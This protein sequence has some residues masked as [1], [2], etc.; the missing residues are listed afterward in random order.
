MGNSEEIQ[1]NL[2]VFNQ[3][4]LILYL[5]NEFLLHI[6]G[7]LRILQTQIEFKQV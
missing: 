3:R 1:E 5:M 2:F 6:R 4:D 7:I